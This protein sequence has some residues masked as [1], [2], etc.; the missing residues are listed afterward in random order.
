MPCSRAYSLCPQVESL[1]L[2]EAYLDGKTM[3]RIAE[4]IKRDILEVTCLNASV[5]VSYNKT[6]AK[7]ASDM[8]KPSGLY[9]IK[10][11]QGL[12]FVDD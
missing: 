11:E 4:A 6:L 1:S 3:W 10:P 12:F 8:D 5:G 2:D 7:I 9:S